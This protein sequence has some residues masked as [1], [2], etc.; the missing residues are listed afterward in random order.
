MVWVQWS[1]AWVGRLQ[2]PP[3]ELRQPG[4]GVPLFAPSELRH[5][6]SLVDRQ[7]AVLEHPP[8]HAA[9]P[10]WLQHFAPLQWKFRHRLA[11]GANVWCNLE[12][13]PPIA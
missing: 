8:I 10:G 3:S 12:R 1:D 9:P 2:G 4:P 11:V 13:Y 7:P 5:L 6:A